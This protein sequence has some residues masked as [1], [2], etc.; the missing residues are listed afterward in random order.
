MTTLHQKTT[1]AAKWSALD[2]FIRQGG[3]F[4]VTIVLARILTPED[5]GVVAMLALFIGVGTVFIDGGFSSAL[6]QRQSTTHTDESTVFV[7]NLG[8][9]AVFG[10]LLCAAAPWIA[11]FFNQPVLQS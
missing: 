9:G 10:V 2:V 3:Q 8:M 5:F 1:N 6:V 11:G 7:F 4:V